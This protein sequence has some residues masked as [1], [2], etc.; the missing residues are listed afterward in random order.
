MASSR[1]WFFRSRPR[2]ATHHIAA[3]LSVIG[4]SNIRPRLFARSNLGHQRTGQIRCVLCS[5][6][7]VASD[8]DR[9]AGGKTPGNSWKAEKS[10]SPRGRFQNGLAVFS[11]LR[12]RNAKRSNVRAIEIQD[13]N[14][15]S[16][17]RSY[18]PGLIQVPLLDVLPVHEI[19]SPWTD[20]LPNVADARRNRF[21]S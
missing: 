4:H 12:I 14:S 3:T 11:H 13:R 19:Q 18:E 6:K 21:V 8:L 10:N 1:Q 9:S 2:E 7:S 15:R 20:G 16:K 17:H 5:S